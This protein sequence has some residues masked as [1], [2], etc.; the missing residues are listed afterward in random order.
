[1]LHKLERYNEARSEVKCAIKCLSQF[2][3]ESQIWKGFNVLYNIETAN[4]NAEAAQAAWQQARDAYL[5][6]R[7]QGG[8]AQFDGGKLVEHVLSLIAQKK[9]SE[10]G[11]LFEELM[12]DVDQPN[13]FK[14]FIQIVAAILNGS[15]NTSPADDMALDYD[16]AAEILFLIE[17][18]GGGAPV[19]QPPG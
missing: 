16:N 12:E 1:M 7:R 5:A 3:H 17:R 8:Y 10:I 2:G 6:Y 4:G 14:Q 19:A 13:W 18:L 15:R 11:P 9:I